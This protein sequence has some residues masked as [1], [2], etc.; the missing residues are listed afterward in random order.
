[1]TWAQLWRTP[2]TKLG[3]MGLTVQ[4]IVNM[5]TRC[6]PMQGHDISILKELVQAAG[7]ER[8]TKREKIP[9]SSRSVYLKWKDFDNSKDR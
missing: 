2:D 4:N 9:R 1:M 7:Q 3:Q 8:I 5:K 6:A